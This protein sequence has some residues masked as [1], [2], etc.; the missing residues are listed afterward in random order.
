MARH[1]P[2]SSKIPDAK[3][4]VLLEYTSPDCGNCA[5]M[6]PMILK[7]AK[8]YENRVAFVEISV[9]DPHLA[10]YLKVYPANLLPTF[11]LLDSSRQVTARYQSVTDPDLI[12]KSIEEVLLKEKTSGSTAR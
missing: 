9:N 12:K 1:S 3:I 6:K 7:L 8:E 11:Y 2:F 4:P 5:Y 10:D